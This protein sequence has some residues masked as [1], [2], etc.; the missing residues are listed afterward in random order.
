[1][2]LARLIAS[3]NQV[4]KHGGTRDQL[5]RELG[6]L[7][8]EMEAAGLMDNFPCLVVRGICDYAD[9]HKNEQW[10]KYAAATAAAYAKELL[11]V[12]SAGHV[13]KMQTAARFM[14]DIEASDD[15]EANSITVSTGGDSDGDSDSELAN[16]EGS[17]GWN[18]AEENIDIEEAINEGSNSRE[19]ASEDIANSLS[20]DEFEETGSEPTSDEESLE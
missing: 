20:D 6:I 4:M 17:S 5:A 13:R 9:S 8:F 2:R 1:M 10:Q 16:G 18:T 19:I 14:S 11:S 12:I 15:S 3:G 7:C